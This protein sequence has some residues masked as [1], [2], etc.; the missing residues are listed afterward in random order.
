MDRINKK[1]LKVDQKVAI[2]ILEFSDAA[3]SVIAREKS[4][5]KKDINNWIIEGVITKIGRR[6]ISIKMEESVSVNEEKF[7]ITK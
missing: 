4:S 7:D 1:N 5:G 3:R 2:K 6:Y